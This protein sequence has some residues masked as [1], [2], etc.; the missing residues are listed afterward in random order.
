HGGL[1]VIVM[2]YLEGQSLSSVISRSRGVNRLPLEMHLRIISDV[3]SGLHYSH[4]L[5]DFDGTSL[6]VVHRD[7]SPHNVFVTF[8]GQV[9]LLDFG[10][11]KLSGSHVETATGVIKGKI[12]YMSPEQI[13]GE[14]VDRRAD[15]FAVGVM[16]W[17]AAA[18]A[19]MWAGMGEAT[20]MNQLLN[21]EL[22]SP[23][24][25]NPEVDDDLER[26]VMRA[27]APNAADRYA[28]AALLQAELDEYLSRFGTQVRPRDIGKAVS[29]LFANER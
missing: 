10:I 3:L 7:M 27:M 20:I 16:L 17:E 18:N 14:N 23:K 29:D 25:T 4:E 5:R 11:A 9:K 1:P 22:P 15:I 26:I 19:R 12:R 2:E 6:N 28:S 24:S 21:A 13:T 8:D